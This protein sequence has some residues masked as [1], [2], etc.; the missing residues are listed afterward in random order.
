M[1]TTTA[2]LL[3]PLREAP[4]ARRLRHA[5]PRLDPVAGL[6]SPGWVEIDQMRSGLLVPR[7]QARVERGAWS[8]RAQAY[9][10]LA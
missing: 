4:C 1:I 2:S 10:K 3:F 7:L 8:V 6:A 5:L 9:C